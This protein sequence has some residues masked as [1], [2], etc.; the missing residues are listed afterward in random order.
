MDVD[1]NRL[2]RR[3]AISAVSWL[4]FF[5]TF[6]LTKKRYLRYGMRNGLAVYCASSYLFCRS[7]LNPF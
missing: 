6:A 1:E 7:N 2:E 5:G 4:V 3:I